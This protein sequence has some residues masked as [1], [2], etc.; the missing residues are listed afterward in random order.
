LA[1]NDNYDKKKYNRDPVLHGGFF[2]GKS[3]NYT[4]LFSMNMNNVCIYVFLVLLILI[5]FFLQILSADCDTC[6]VIEIVGLL[7]IKIIYICLYANE[8]L[9]TRDPI[10]VYNCM[11]TMDNFPNNININNISV[12]V[13]FLQNSLKTN[14]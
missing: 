14:L 10:S 6:I 7:N 2:G 9:S 3:P 11:T 12:N 4:S 13:I 1:L 5:Y 8:K